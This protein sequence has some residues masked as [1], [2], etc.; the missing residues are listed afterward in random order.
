M[1]EN[2]GCRRSSTNWTIERVAGTGDFRDF[3]GETVYER[4]KG[5]R[6]VPAPAD[7]QAR[8]DL[9]ARQA[10]RVVDFIGGD[11]LFRGAAFHRAGMD[12]EL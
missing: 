1:S 2:R 12:V 6:T 5:F 4:R 9:C 3:V 11:F 7:I 10:M 8:G